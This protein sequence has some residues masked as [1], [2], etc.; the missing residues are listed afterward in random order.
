VQDTAV[1]VESGV[2]VSVKWRTGSE[3]KGHAAVEHEL[4]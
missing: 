3:L 1:E 4:V 2:A